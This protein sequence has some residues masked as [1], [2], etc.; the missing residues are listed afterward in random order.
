MSKNL[1]SNCETMIIRKKNLK[2]R[3]KKK[4]EIKKQNGWLTHRDVTFS[5][6][7]EVWSWWWR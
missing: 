6:L 1:I 4:E 2:Y 5:P 3:E 7:S